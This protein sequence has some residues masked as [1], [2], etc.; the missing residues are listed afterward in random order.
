M[1]RR[2]LDPRY[3]VG[4]WPLNGHA[5]DVSGHGNHGVWSGTEAYGAFFKNSRQCAVFDGASQVAVADNP[6][7]NSACGVGQPR[8][9]SLW[10]RTTTV[11]NL[12]LI[13]KG[14]NENFALQSWTGVNAG[15]II[16]IVGGGPIG[17]TD[18]TFNDGSWHHLCGVYTG[19]TMILYIDDSLQAST[20]RAASASNSSRLTFGARDSLV[21]PYVGDFANVRIYNIELTRDEILKLFHAP[22]PT[23]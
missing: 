15:R 11:E 9:I 18:N 16:W 21:A 8:T 10:F 2:L 3:L 7:I 1:S 17:S 20:V 13:D 23:Y 22:V 5:Q 6:Q 4:S 19:T 14:A 12:V